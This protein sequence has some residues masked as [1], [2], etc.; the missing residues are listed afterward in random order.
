LE[1]AEGCYLNPCINVFS[2]KGML[3]LSCDPSVDFLESAAAS[4]SVL[5]DFL[6]KFDLSQIVDQK[7]GGEVFDVAF[8]HQTFEVA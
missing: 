3:P 6:L 4:M 8:V 5:A 2:S 1:I 7:E